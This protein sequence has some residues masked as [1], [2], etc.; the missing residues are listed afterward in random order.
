M[1]K[2][3]R[4]R[5][6]LLLVMGP[7]GCL[8]SGNEVGDD[9]AQF[10]PQPPGEGTDDTGETGGAEAGGQPT[11]EDDIDEYNALTAELE[12]RRT[13]FGGKAMDEIQ[14]VGDRLFW[15]EFPGWDPVLRSYDPAD[16][17]TVPYAFS[18]G[19]G[20]AYNYRASDAAVLTAI[21]NGDTV[22]YRMYDIDA[23]DTLLAEIELDAPK[24]EQ[25]WWAYAVDGTTGYIVTTDD[26]V[27]LYRFD[28][29]GE[30]QH[31]LDLEEDAGAAVSIF[32]EFGIEGQ[33]MLFVE[34]GRIWQ[35]DLAGGAA[36]WL[37]NETEVTG[38]VNF[39]SDGAAFGAA[40]GLFYF[41]YETGTLTDVDQRITDN[42]YVFNETFA[43][44]H[45]HAGGDWTRLGSKIVYQSMSGI[46][47]YD[48]ERDEIAP[49]LLDPRLEPP[50]R[51]T[52]RNPQILR[53]GEIFIQG[54]FSESGAVG[55]DGP[56]YRVD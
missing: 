27:D 23:P 21:Q 3:V 18:I 26:G 49:I 54:L 36:E 32:W 24:D 40:N 8:G 29:G 10:E 41:D 5:L 39:D 43:S 15:L 50:E 11:Q 53:T 14:A 16:D 25:R 56:I 7:A 47:Q 45:L 55:A 38:S 33:T 17:R 4:L 42:D 46:F 13:E 44:A 12:A 35:L 1:F 31:I 51:L 22:L 37:G 48:L 52:Y 28:P 34:S 2:S 20:D 30:V 6:G 9:A 19:G